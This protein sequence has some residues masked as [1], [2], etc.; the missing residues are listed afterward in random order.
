MKIDIKI[1]DV[2][3]SGEW[4][5]KF[6]IGT[7]PFY[8]RVFLKIKG[9]SQVFHLTR[10]QYMDISAQRVIKMY[11]QLSSEE[12]KRVIKEIGVN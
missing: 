8:K 2:I 12:K 4:N 11:Q 1:K 3:I 6:Y 9:D 10:K 7:K 5:K